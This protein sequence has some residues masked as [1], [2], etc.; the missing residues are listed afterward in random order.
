[1]QPKAQN[2]FTPEAEFFGLIGSRIDFQ[3]H[4][5]W[6]PYLEFMVK[7]N[8]WIAKNEFLDNNFSFRLGVSVRF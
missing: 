2:F 4:R 1:M 3:L 7:T 5:H 8:G 6:L